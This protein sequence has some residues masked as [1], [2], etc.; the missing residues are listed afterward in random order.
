MPRDD[1]V[2]YEESTILSEAMRNEARAAT[3]SPSRL[4]GTAWVSGKDADQQ[5]HKTET[6][7]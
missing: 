3:S 7:A 6:V 2:P 4:A 1:Q 5:H